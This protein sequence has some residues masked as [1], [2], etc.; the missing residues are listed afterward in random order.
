[1]TFLVVTHIGM[2]LA[3]IGIILLQPGKSD[4]GIG[5]GSTS[6]SIFGSKGAGNFLTKLTTTCAIIYLV[7]SFVLTR[8]RIAEA[9]RTV[10]DSTPLTQ[11]ETET[12]QD[13]A[14]EIPAKTETPEK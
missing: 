9:E 7:T 11:G 10:I 1:V 14:V 6:Q 12:R 8:A 13:P 5:F 3:L 2:C 4:M